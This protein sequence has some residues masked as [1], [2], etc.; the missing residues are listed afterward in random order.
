VLVDRVPKTQLSCDSISEPVEY[1]QAVGS[2]W[3]GGQPD[4]LAG[5]YVI[6][7][8]L[9]RRRSSMVEFVDDHDIKVIGRKIGEIGA[10]QSLN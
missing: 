1:R 5:P 10:L 4:Q 7:E 3:C 2:L 9:I 6:K 8:P